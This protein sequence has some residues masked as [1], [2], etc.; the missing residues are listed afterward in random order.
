MIHPNPPNSHSNSSISIIS[1][2]GWRKSPEKKRFEEC[3]SLGWR[4]EGHVMC[5]T[6]NCCKCQMGSVSISGNSTKWLAPAT[7]LEEK[8]S[9]ELWFFQCRI[10]RF[11]EMFPWSNHC[12]F[13]CNPSYQGPYPPKAV[14][15]SSLANKFAIFLVCVSGI[16]ESW[17]PLKNKCTINWSYGNIKD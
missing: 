8:S 6:L 17:S 7:D 5:C 16:F 1:D 13:T 10:L 12:I 11:W 9:P 3:E 2:I 4:S 15:S 14:S